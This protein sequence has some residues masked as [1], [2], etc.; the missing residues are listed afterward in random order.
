LNFSSEDTLVIGELVYIQDSPIIREIN[1]AYR[2]GITVSVR[3]I[4]DGEIIQATTQNDGFFFFHNIKEG[5]Y[6]LV[7]T[8]FSRQTRDMSWW[9]GDRINRYFIVTE[10]K[11][12]NLGI[13]I[14]GRGERQYTINT[15]NYEDVKNNFSHKYPNIFNDSS[16]VNAF[17]FY[18]LPIFTDQDYNPDPE[19]WDITL[20]DTAR[21]VDYLTEADKNIILELNKVRSDP[22][23]YAELYIKP[24]LQYFDGYLYTEPGKEKITQEGI[25]PAEECYYFL[26]RM[27]SVPILF[28]EKGL[29]L[30]AKDHVKDQC[31]AGIT[32]HTG[33]DR[34]GPRDRVMRYGTGDYIGENIAYGPNRAD[35]LVI[36]WLID[37]GVPDRGHRKS[38]LHPEFSQV[39]VATG[40]HR[41]YGTMCV[42]EMTAGYK[43]LYAPASGSR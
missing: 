9:L 21:N 39:G 10:G 5:I 40:T 13:I 23:K 32:G 31:P 38:L 33:T 42:I 28:P 14:Q 3:N 27:R 37:D 22:R 29:S 30:G 8:G 6:E 34:S 35:E 43:T 20:L 12:N 11:I 41:R 16:W 17:I 18:D 24:R 26:S 2:K 19:N 7:Q 15:D 25:I 1:G 4:S 36:S